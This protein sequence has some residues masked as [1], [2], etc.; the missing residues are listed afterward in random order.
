MTEPNLEGL[1]LSDIDPRVWKL[2]LV[3]DSTIQGLTL[4]ANALALGDNEA[5]REHGE[6]IRDELLPER[7]A[8]LLELIEATS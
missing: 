1:E 3:D 6:Y 4:L 2:I 7:K 5:A 8:L